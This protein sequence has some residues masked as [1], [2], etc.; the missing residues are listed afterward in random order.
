MSVFHIIKE[1]VWYA[2]LST[3]VIGGWVEFKEYQAK[4]AR[5]SQ[6]FGKRQ[7]RLAKYHRLH[8]ATVKTHAEVKR[9]NRDRERNRVQRS[10]D[11]NEK[12]L[13]KR[14]S[15]VFCVDRGAGR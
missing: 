13:S 5:E 6:R 12:D 1:I 15:L 11:W 4:L 2:F 10:F 8:I 9:V 3:F 7:A 14:H